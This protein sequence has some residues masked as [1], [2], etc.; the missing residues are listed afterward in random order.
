LVVSD[1]LFR[2]AR[3]AETFRIFA[4]LNRFPTLTGEA[5]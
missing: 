1:Q 2:P 3:K 5:S 4:Y